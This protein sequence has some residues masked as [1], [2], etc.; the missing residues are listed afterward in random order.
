MNDNRGQTIFLSVI[1]IATLL[2]AII[3]A[4][5]AYFTTTMSGTA[6]D[7]KATTGTL[8]K[9]EFTA[10]A[11][12]LDKILPGKKSDDK[13]LTVSLGASDF[14]VKYACYMNVTGNEVTDMYLELTD[15]DTNPAGTDIVEASK[16][17]QISKVAYVEYNTPGDTESGIKTP[18]GTAEK[19][20]IAKGTLT[21]NSTKSLKYAIHFKETGVE[22]NEQQGSRF[23]ASVYCELES[24]SGVYYN[25]ANQNGTTTKPVAE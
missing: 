24:A 7:V 17:K 25:N 21:A 15:G 23:D 19:I 9:V 4:T 14:D 13:T 6:Q 8:G 20:E 16:N 18:A 12:N 11:I 3:G 10:E 5:F 2:V 1:G 22:Q